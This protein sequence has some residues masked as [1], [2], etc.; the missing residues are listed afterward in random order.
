MAKNPIFCRYVP[1]YNGSLAVT[2]AVDGVGSI[3]SPSGYLITARLL[4][5]GGNPVFY[6]GRSFHLSPYFLCRALRPLLQN[7][8]WFCRPRSR[9]TS[10]PLSSEYSIRPEN[11][12]RLSSET[13]GGARAGAGGFAGHA[14]GEPLFLYPLK[15]PTTPSGSYPKP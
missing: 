10:L 1:L 9:T 2:V 13:A 12:I 14:H 6:Y 15:L 4:G 8:R 11:S 5:R 7:P 3:G